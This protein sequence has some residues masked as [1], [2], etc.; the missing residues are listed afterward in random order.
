[1]AIG[2]RGVHS[3]E[4]ARDLF[5]AFFSSQ[6]FISDG[7]HKGCTRFEPS[8]S[9]TY[10]LDV[11]GGSAMPPCD[12]LVSLLAVKS[13]EGSD[14]FGKVP[15]RTVVPIGVKTVGISILWRGMSNQRDIRWT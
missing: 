10:S 14:D 12:V 8:R 2:V 3:V 15:G 5:L 13:T 4:I 7:M 1:M 6:F 11:G 9:A